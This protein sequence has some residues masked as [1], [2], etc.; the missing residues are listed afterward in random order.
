MK[1]C[2]LGGGNVYAL[3]FA[4]ALHAEGIDHFGIG[5]SG[6][7]EPAF[8]QVKHEYRFYAMHLIN[9]LYNVLDCLSGEKPDVIVNF[10][11]QGERAASFGSAAGRFY[12]TNTVALVDLVEALAMRPW[13]KRFIQISTSELYGS[14][15]EPATELSPLR[16]SSPYAVSKAA[17]D[18]HLWI[19]RATRGF[20]MN[21]I[22][23]SNAY[24]P[25]QQLHRV[26]P[27]AIIRAL[28]GRRIPLHGGGKARK[29]YMHASDLSRAIIR[30]ILSGEV[31]AIYNCGPAHPISIRTLVEIVAVACGKRL[32]DIAD[33]APAREGEDDCYWIDSSALNLGTGWK[34]E[35]PL[36]H[37]IAEMVQWVRDHPEVMTMNDEY[38]LLP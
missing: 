25:G 32:G 2:I 33:D 12:Q 28:T 36:A 27:R 35:I 21:V 5:R 37:G 14:T 34:P 20:P 19:M 15:V 17:F 30:V 31:G 6:P 23:P 18:E 10:A 4:Q 26:I 16:S 8:W 29:S 24:C 7:K 9:D 38:R 3:N 22:R 13:L 1:V 11:A